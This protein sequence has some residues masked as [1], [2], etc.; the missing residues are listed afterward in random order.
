MKAANTDVATTETSG[1]LFEEEWSLH[2]IT[3]ETLQ[4]V[5]SD[6]SCKSLEVIAAGVEAEFESQF[7]GRLL[8]LEDMAKDLAEFEWCHLCIP[9][10]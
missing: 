8:E 3:V 7:G 6:L 5:L 10:Q 4:Q 1:K 9:L 2:A